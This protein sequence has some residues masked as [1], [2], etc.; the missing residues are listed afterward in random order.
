MELATLDFENVLKDSKNSRQVLSEVAFC[1]YKLC[2]KALPLTK[3][4]E[5]ESTTT[6]TTDAHVTKDDLAI[7]KQEMMSALTE[8][9]QKKETATH[10]VPPSDNDMTHEDE[11]PKSPTAFKLEVELPCEESEGGGDVASPAKGEEVKEAK[12]T[13]NPWSLAARRGMATKLGEI[14]IPAE[15]FSVKKGG[16]TAIVTFGT[17]EAKDKAKE[18]LGKD[19]KVTDGSKE[20]KKLLPRLRLDKV[21]ASLLEGDKDAV[22]TAIK[23]SLLLKNQLVSKALQDNAQLTL[24]VIHFDKKREFAVLKVSPAIKTLIKAGGNRLYLGCKVQQATDYVHLVQCYNCNAFG[25]KADAC[26]RRGSVC[27]YCAGN[28]RSH[29]CTK[30]KQPKDYR[31]INCLN[32]ND[33]H[34]SSHADHAANDELCPC[35]IGEHDYAISRLVDSAV[36]KNDY[37]RKIQSLREQER[38]H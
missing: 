35:V 30:K 2:E 27:L 19:Y 6:T 28:H 36:S 38:R 14:P 4:A 5:G 17:G 16:R 9:L 7:F 11:D 1:L 3:I 37:R 18:T 22:K 12:E 33:K 29:S 32:S 10:L 13:K 31:C 20:L 24:D 26:S 25:H 23:D 21:D 15:N 34:L 8:A